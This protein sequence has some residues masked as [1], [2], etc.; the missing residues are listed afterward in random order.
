MTSDLRIRLLDFFGIPY[1]LIGFRP[2][3]NW[4][5]KSPQSPVF[6]QSRPTYSGTQIHLTK[7]LSLPDVVHEI[8]HYVVAS[9]A[10]RKMPNYGCG[11]DP[12]GGIC[13]EMIADSQEMEVR[14][15]VIDVALHY[16]LKMDWVDRISFLNLTD[17]A[18]FRREKR[19]MWST[20]DEFLDDPEYAYVLRELQPGD[21]VSLSS[22]K[23]LGRS[24]GKIQNLCFSFQQPTASTTSM[25]TP[26]GERCSGDS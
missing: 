22:M 4:K 23:L 2:I 11:S 14:A 8:A 6:V 24:L 20:I 26:K 13:D 7:T 1:A 10:E 9:P 3:P 16:W 21:F 18:D 19:E 12:Y 15:C 25:S 5:E 17:F